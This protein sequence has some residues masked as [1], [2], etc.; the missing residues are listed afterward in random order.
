MGRAL[1]VAI[2]LV[3]LLTVVLFFSGW[4]FPQG[5][6]EYAPG[7]DRQFLLTMII[8]GIAF[9]AAQ[10]GLG[11]AIW[12][13]RARPNDESRAVYTHG[14][15]RLEILW[16]VVTAVVFVAVAVIG[17]TV[18]AQMHFQSAPAG[19]T[20]VV[21]VAQQFAWNF[22]Y[23]G[24]DGRFGRTAP[25]LVND[26]AANPIGLDQFDAAARDDAQVSTLVVP[27]NQ[28][29]E[30][31]LR[32]KDVIHSFWVPHLRVKQDL[33]PGMDIRIHFTATRTGRYE[34]ACAEL[35]GAQ[36]YRMKS[37][38]IVVTPEEHRQLMGLRQDDFLTRISEL[39]RQYP[40]VA[41]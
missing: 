41:E 5:I 36:H 27:V 6:S 40:I 2:W 8:V 25:S 21:A 19:A 39:I 12:R 37:F 29:V 20:Q 9:V 38:L 30:I 18:W 15:N 24:A 33:M 13:F 14:S 23:P 28:P 3:T 4:W 22:H 11:Y 32:S 16:T 31:I 35:C 1:A 17:Q 26:A 7:I 34:L 10:V